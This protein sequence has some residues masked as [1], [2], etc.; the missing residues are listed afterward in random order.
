VRVYF[1]DGLPAGYDS[2]LTATI[3]PTLVSISPS[4]GSAG[5]TLITVTG[6]GFGTDSADLNLQH[7]SGS[8]ICDEVNVTGYGTFTCLTKVMEIS[9]SDAINLKL[10]SDIYFC[11]NSDGAACGFEQLYNSS[12]TLTSVTLI[13][14]TCLQVQGTDFPTSSYDVVAIFKGI[15]SSSGII[16]SSS[17]VEV[18][19]DKGVPVS[20][21]SSTVVL[22][23]DHQTLNE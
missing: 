1:A 12:P 16:D 19:F 9:S 18:C 21:T 10:G 14:G 6:T 4:T 3:A 11:G 20:Q 15:E 8:D 13:G 7:S 2:F 23:F 17:S 22:R 5:G